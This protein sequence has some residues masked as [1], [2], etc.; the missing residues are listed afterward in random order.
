M[1]ILYKAKLLINDGVIT[2]V[3]ANG[4]QEQCN[5]DKLR[6]FLLSFKSQY[7]Q[8]DSIAELNHLVNDVVAIIDPSGVLKVFDPLLFQVVFDSSVRYIPLTEYAKKHNKQRSILCRYCREGRIPGAIQ[9]EQRWLIPE[10]APYPN[11]E[12]RGPKPL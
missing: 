4:T 9:Q 10:D 12:K 8:I 3:Y 5:K 1:S 11:M 6:T 7:Y 2:L